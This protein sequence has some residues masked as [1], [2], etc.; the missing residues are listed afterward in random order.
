VPSSPVAVFFCLLPAFCWTSSFSFLPFLNFVV[1]ATLL[2]SFR[3]PLDSRISRICTLSFSTLPFQPNPC[4]LFFPLCFLPS[5]KIG[6]HLSLRYS[7][8]PFVP[9]PM[10]PFLVTFA[11]PW[12]FPSLYF[13][14]L[15]FIVRISFLRQTTPFPSGPQKPPF[16]L[17]GYWVSLW[18]PVFCEY[19]PEFSCF[20]PP[21]RLSFEI[22]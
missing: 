21:F 5:P 11:F 12:R 6:V 15:G 9:P 13:W 3:L 7:T 16:S 22:S 1:F 19:P 8:S 17:P 18:L 4:L 20:P 14:S 10:C 2:R